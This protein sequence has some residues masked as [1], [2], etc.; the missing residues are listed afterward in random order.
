MKK[1]LILLATMGLQMAVGQGVLTF[2]EVVQITL[3]NNYDIRIS[4]NQSQIANNNNTV[5]N[6]GFLP[7]INAGADANRASRDSRLVFF[8]GQEVQAEGARSEALNAFVQLDWT[9]FDGFKMF[10]TKAKLNDLQSLGELELKYQIEQVVLQ[11]GAIY[12]RL[13]QE[14]K[15][16]KVYQNTA[17]I[18]EQQLTIT[19]RAY[20]LGGR[21]EL[22]LLNAQVALN[23]DKARVLEQ[24]MLIKNLKADL[25]QLMALRPDNDFQVQTAITLQPQP[26]LTDLNQQ[27][28]SQN[29]ALK[30][31]RVR[32]QVSRREIDEIRAGLYPTIGVFSD[33]SYNRQANEVGVLES[34]LTRGTNFGVSVRWNLFNGLNDRREIQNR[35]LVF[36][37]AH[38]ESEKILL[39][40]QTAI[41]QRF[42]EYAY[43]KELLQL[44]TENL[45]TTQRNL[46]VAQK[47]FE[48]GAINDLDL[49]L[50]QLT[51]LES[52]S[53]QLRAEYL[54]KIAEIQLMQLSGRLF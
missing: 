53:R 42:N 20:D 54:T 6:A 34:N 26:G 40:S 33:F 35:K 17:A 45:G 48:L 44:E 3:A 47:S 36:E 18:T 8:S 41:Y 28:E 51:E 49:R 31:V 46:Q 14:E 30:A 23:T 7:T 2:D 52:A 4:G 50:I 11:L 38:L 29:I 27:L 9:V 43:A 39:E 10:T 24:T 16:L 5:G 25:N 19:T 1:F 32:K 37:N 13:V 15:L 21:S 12:F 22:E